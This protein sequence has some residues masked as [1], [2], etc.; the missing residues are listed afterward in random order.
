MSKY[1]NMGKWYSNKSED[2]EE[3]EEDVEEDV[4]EDD[5]DE[6]E[7]EE[8]QEEEE[9]K[10]EVVEVKNVILK[11]KKVEKG[12]NEELSMRIDKDIELRWLMIHYC[13]KVKINYLQTKFM[14]NGARV[15]DND[16]P[17]LLSMHDYDVIHVLPKFANQDVSLRGAVCYKTMCIRMHKRRDT[18]VRVTCTDPLLQQLRRHFSYEKAGKLVSPYFVYNGFPLRDNLS[19]DRLSMDDGDI[20][21]AFDFVDNSSSLGIFTAMT[22]RR[23][24][25]VNHQNRKSYNFN[26]DKSTP[27]TTVAQKYAESIGIKPDRVQLFLFGRRLSLDKTV[28]EEQ[29]YDN[30]QIDAFVNFS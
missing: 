22:R 3:E 11:V 24:L 18:F 10:K 28:E 23:M 8:S 29:L 9:V 1:S 2:E 15:R 5:E 17:L 13:H 30:C 4:E 27:L 7:E 25:H 16:T 21:D 19:V 12:V 6:E 14:F 20:V 26:A